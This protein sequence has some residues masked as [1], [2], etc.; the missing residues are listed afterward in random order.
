MQYRS[1]EKDTKACSTGVEKRVLEYL[2]DNVH[3]HPTGFVLKND[4]KNSRSFQV[5]FKNSR[6][7]FNHKRTKM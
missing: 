7:H 1:R 4:E 3:I 6:S 2:W 5:F